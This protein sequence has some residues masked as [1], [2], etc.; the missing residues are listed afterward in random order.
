MTDDDINP[1]T[2]RGQLRV[3]LSLVPSAGLIHCAHSFMD[4]ARKY[5]PYNWRDKKVPARIYIAAAQRHLLDWLDGEEVASDSKAHH[6]GHAMACCAII[7]DAMETG[8]LIDDRPKKGSA[9]KLLAKLEVEL[10]A[11]ARAEAELLAQNADLP[12]AKPSAKRKTMTRKRLKARL[13][14]RGK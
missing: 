10:Q 7:L 11:Q 3:D 14:K 9:A 2:L 13:N 12:M 6:L 8:N 5:N 1:K 4:G